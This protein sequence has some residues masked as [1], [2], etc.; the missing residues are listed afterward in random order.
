MPWCFQFVVSAITAINSKCNAVIW[1]VSSLC[2]ILFNLPHL[3]STSLP[4]DTLQFY[5]WLCHRYE[6]NI[7]HAFCQFFS[8]YI[9][10]YAV[11]WINTWYWARFLILEVYLCQENQKASSSICPP[12]LGPQ[13]KYVD[14]IPQA[15]CL[16]HMLPRIVL[17][18]DVDSRSATGNHLAVN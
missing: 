18:L 17:V 3:G 2:N 11:C 16:R 7:S 1:S 15:S 12:D 14:C 9:L 6:H 13:K 5:L 4:A 10:Y 8:I